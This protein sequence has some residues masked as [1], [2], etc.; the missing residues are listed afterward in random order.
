MSVVSVAG[1]IRPHTLG[2]LRS[3]QKHVVSSR[4][5]SR[6][7]GCHAH[8]LEST[9]NIHICNYVYIYKYYIY[10]YNITGDALICFDDILE[11][12]RGTRG[13]GLKNCE[14]NGLDMFGQRFKSFHI[15]TGPNT[16]L[17]TQRCPKKNREIHT[18]DQVTCM[19]SIARSAGTVAS[20]AAQHDLRKQ[21]TKIN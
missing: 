17:M 3:T 7:L 14:S 10:V 9:G 1:L 5:E 2:S 8:I 21:L 11:N 19:G 6:A 16:S 12:I 4:I 18:N 15:P 13:P 20:L